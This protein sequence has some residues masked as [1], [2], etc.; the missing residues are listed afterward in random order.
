[1]AK[2][3]P[4]SVAWVVVRSRTSGSSQD[5]MKATATMGTV[6]RKTVDSDWA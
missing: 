3:W 2:V 4:M 5:N 1:M 6:T